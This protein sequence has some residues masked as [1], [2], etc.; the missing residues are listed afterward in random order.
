MLENCVSIQ[1]LYTQAHTGAF[2]QWGGS[3]ETLV[4]KGNLFKM[5]MEAEKH[6]TEIMREERS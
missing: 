5:T 6:I 2:F 3:I 1:S 4:G